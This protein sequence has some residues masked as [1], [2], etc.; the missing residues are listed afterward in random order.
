M[1]N[2]QLNI[3]LDS[4]AIALAKVEAKRRGLSLTQHIRHL[5]V[6]TPGELLANAS[7]GKLTGGYCGYVLATAERLKDSDEWNAE[8]ADWLGDADLVLSWLRVNPWANAAPER[9]ARLFANIPNAVRAA[10]ALEVAA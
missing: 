3:R 7:G 2:Q 1:A 4:E 5:L 8:C 10:C 6:A 9:V